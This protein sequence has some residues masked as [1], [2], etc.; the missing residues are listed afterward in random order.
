M[1]KKALDKGLIGSYFL[2]LKKDDVTNKWDKIKQGKILDVTS[3]Y[4][5]VEELSWFDCYPVKKSLLLL[6]ELINNE[7]KETRFYDSKKD[8]KVQ[9]SRKRNLLSKGLETQTA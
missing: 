9:R 3:G 1:R 2:C 5:Y 7:S 6:I 8:L 4:A